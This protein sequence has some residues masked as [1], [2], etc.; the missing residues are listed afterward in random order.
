MVEIG[1]GTGVVALGL[2]RRGFSVVGV[3]LSAP[4]LAFAAGRL[5]PAV[6][7]A[8]ACVLPFPNDSIANAVS[9]WVVHAVASRHA[10]FLEVA[11]VLRTGGRY[12]VCPTNRSPDGDVFDQIITSMYQ[13]AETVHPA[14][15]YRP[16]DV[17][18]IGQMATEAALQMHVEHFAPRQ[19]ETSAAEHI[20]NIVDRAWPAL[21]GLDDDAFRYVTEPALESL[22]ALPDGPIV[23]HSMQD[24]AVLSHH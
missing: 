19:W 16:V 8:D 7:R 18:E 2:Q 3:D 14:W 24:I 6:V 12:L 11:R 22:R 20:Q 10:L 4:M 13:R 9:V 21:I 1:V 17:T 23:K 5:G 15:R